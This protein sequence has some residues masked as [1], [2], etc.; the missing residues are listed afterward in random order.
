MYL[1]LAKF[2]TKTFLSPLNYFDIFV[3]YQLTVFVGLLSNSLVHS[4]DL[5]VCL[6]ASTL[7]S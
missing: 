2:I 7:P 5:Y 6:Y 1:V 3:E 4:V